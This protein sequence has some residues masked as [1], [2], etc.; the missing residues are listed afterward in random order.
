MSRLVKRCSHAP[1]APATNTRR[2]RASRRRVL[3]LTAGVRGV[4]W[5][6]RSLGW[7]WTSKQAFGAT[8][9]RTLAKTFA[10]DSPFFRQVSR[11]CNYI[12][13][14]MPTSSRLGA[15]LVT[16][17]VL[18]RSCTEITP[19]G[20]S[21]THGTRAAACPSEGLC[22]RAAR[23]SQSRA[24]RSARRLRPRTPDSRADSRPSPSRPPSCRVAARAR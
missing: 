9:S 23:A 24:R 15:A 17:R 21:L 10:F 14:A 12:I 13:P 1:L 19:A 5:Q 16:R 4:T 6:R 20:G 18:S 7:F 8:L 11:P 2:T 22:R 3:G